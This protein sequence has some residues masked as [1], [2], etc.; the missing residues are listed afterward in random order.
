MIESPYGRALV[1]KTREGWKILP[2]VPPPKEGEVFLSRGG[3]RFLL[4]DMGFRQM[5]VEYYYNYAVRQVVRKAIEHI[6]QEYQRQLQEKSKQL[7][8]ASRVQSVFMKAIEE[9]RRFV[10]QNSNVTEK[11]IER[12]FTQVFTQELNK[13]N[14]ELS[15][16]G[17]KVN[18]TNIRF[19]K[20]ETG[21]QPVIEYT[22]ESTK[23][24]SIKI[25]TVFTGVATL[26]EATRRLYSTVKS[27]LTERR[28]IITRFMT[29]LE[30]SFTKLMSAVPSPEEVE[31][32]RKRLEQL[33]AQVA[34]IGDESL[35]TA[36][37]S[38]IN[39]YEQKLNAYIRKLHEIGR[40]MTPWEA[41]VTGLKAAAMPVFSKIVELGTGAIE[42]ATEH[43]PL[44]EKWKTTIEGGLIAARTTVKTWE[45]ELMKE[46]HALRYASPEAKTAFTIG[47]SAAEV[48]LSIGTFGGWAIGETAISF[49]QPQ[50][51]EA[52]L[53][54][55][56]R[57]TELGIGPVRAEDIAAIVV[58]VGAAAAVA[59]GAQL[60]ARLGLQSLARGLFRIS[61]GIARVMEYMPDVLLAKGATRLG[62]WIGRRII[63]AATRVTARIP[64]IT[65]IT[66]RIK[67]L[68]ERLRAE[69]PRS[70]Q[71]VYAL[72]FEVPKVEIKRTPTGTYTVE[73][74]T[75]RKLYVLPKPVKLSELSRAV[76]RA[77]Q[78][79]SQELSTALTAYARAKPEVAQI[80]Q[81]GVTL[82]KTRRGLVTLPTGEFRLEELRKL[83]LPEEVLKELARKGRATLEAV[84]AIRGGVAHVHPELLIYGGVKKPTTIRVS[85][86]AKLTAGPVT[87]YKM[88]VVTGRRTAALL[89]TVETPAIKRERI[90]IT[91]APGKTVVA[92]RITA[93]TPAGVVE[94]VCI[95]GA[96][97]GYVAL[98]GLAKATRVPSRI[99]FTEALR[100]RG[101][102]SAEEIVK[103]FASAIAT[104]VETRAGRLH[105]YGVPVVESRL[106]RALEMPKRGRI[107]VE[108]SGEKYFIRIGEES[109]ELSSKPEVRV[110]N[111]G[112]TLVIRTERGGELR[113]EVGREGVY[114]VTPRG[115]KVPVEGIVVREG[116]LQLRI[117]GETIE[118]KPRI[119][120]TEWHEIE[121]F[122]HEASEAL[123]RR[124]LPK[125]E[126]KL[127]E[128]STAHEAGAKAEER[129][130][131]EV[132]GRAEAKVE[133][134]PAE[135][136][137]EVGKAEVSVSVEKIEL[138]PP[139]VHV[140]VEFTGNKLKIGNIEYDVKYRGTHVE[141]V[142]QTFPPMT[143][144]E[145]NRIYNYIS[146]VIDFLKKRLN[147]D[148]NVWFETL[149]TGGFRVHILAGRSLLE[150]LLAI[151][152]NLRVIPLPVGEIGKK[153]RFKE[154]EKPEAQPAESSLTTAT[155]PEEDIELEVSLPVALLVLPVLLKLPLSTLQSVVVKLPNP[156]KKVLKKLLEK[157]NIEIPEVTLAAAAGLRMIGV[158]RSPRAILVL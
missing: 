59:K 44:P 31:R 111:E 96:R 100:I 14:Q 137:V 136:L 130:V 93:V 148:V 125:I 110:E 90:A 32:F 73:V 86:S 9:T 98:E 138:K 105:F 89:E 139:E 92:E 67:P 27:I 158:G 29:E 76:E 120:P 81:T 39:E 52:R 20:T 91:R 150:G 117:G 135:K 116:K 115:E 106:P 61:T 147:V 74:R 49:T 25:P 1:W 127:E 40:K 107:T 83:G 33:K 28:N 8:V 149:P 53:A 85:E 38:I 122:Y 11:D 134:K 5:P 68:I 132:R 140:Q 109:F 57:E 4:Y 37:T 23:P 103:G 95:G 17:I 48:G 121:K 45:R 6:R 34:Q 77:A 94:K 55:F 50:S 64:G 114:V 133:V 22:V 60:A 21:I 71:K 141:L 123:R 70:E 43:L 128:R 41:F 151:L 129:G 15:K 79:I 2:L 30:R 75:E 51:L 10:E 66:T 144:E 146:K 124:Y 63:T 119:R 154:V 113:I 99:S 101:L 157:F 84:M 47:A 156:L 104:G 35:R 12:Y 145:L 26:G 126:A 118:I 24:I 72:E 112:R 3:P 19:E 56:R 153:V 58:P 46:L 152:P 7:N 54:H 143:R 18:V 102:Q 65:R 87:S 108:R 13:L 16:H 69:L 82:V 97:R 155:T 78:E 131:P 62:R 36:L 142:S 42:W 88:R 80:V